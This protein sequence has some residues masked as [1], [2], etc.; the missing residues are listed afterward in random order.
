MCR[1]SRRPFVAQMRGGQRQTAATKGNGMNQLP[2]LAKA[3]CDD[4]RRAAEHRRPCPQAY[5]ARRNGTRR[6]IV[7]LTGLRLRLLPA[8]LR[9]AGQAF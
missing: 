7:R 8:A 2:E 6:G 4:K 3:I 5:A 9:R 1:S